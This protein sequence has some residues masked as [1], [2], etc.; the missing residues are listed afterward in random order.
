MKLLHVAADGIDLSDTFQVT[1][2]R[3]NHPVL[4]CS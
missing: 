3:A 2:L 1:Q 4:Q